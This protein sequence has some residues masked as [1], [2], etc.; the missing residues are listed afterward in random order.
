MGV[1][2]LLVV[3]FFMV[4]N[5]SVQIG[6]GQDAKR[7]N[8][9]KA[10]KQALDM[11]YND[12]NCYPKTIP[13]DLNGRWAEKNGTVVYMIKVPE[14]YSVSVIPTPWKEPASGYVYQ[15]DGSTCPQWNVVYATYSKVYSASDCPLSALNQ[16]NYA[17]ARGC[18]LSGNT[19]CSFISS[20]QPPP[21]SAVP[22]GVSG[23]TPTDIIGQCG[24]EPK[25]YIKSSSGNCNY[26]PAVGVYCDQ[27]CTKK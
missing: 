19:D 3:A 27:Y 21:P 17:S 16:C 15:T 2:G 9:L 14:V 5:P 20:N 25:L 18:S 24:T 8:D 1:I 12:H 23:P 6:K 22:T 13:A 4:F 11:Y 7:K 26:N 10:L